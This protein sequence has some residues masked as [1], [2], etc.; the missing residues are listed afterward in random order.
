[1]RWETPIAVHRWGVY[2]P[3]G[4]QSR[5]RYYEVWKMIQDETQI[6]LSR[7]VTSQKQ[8]QLAPLPAGE[9]RYGKSLGLL[10][11]KQHERVFDAILWLGEVELRDAGDT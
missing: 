8:E 2:H 6:R 7:E 3:G 1:M 9:S 5:A 11:P 10:V 4:D